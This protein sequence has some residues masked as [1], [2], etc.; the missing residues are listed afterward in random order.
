MSPEHTPKVEKDAGIAFDDMVG[1]TIAR[2]EHGTTEGAYGDEPTVTLHFTDGT[3]HT[4]VLAADFA[5]GYD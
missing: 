5:P 4:F 1:R 3:C 2:L